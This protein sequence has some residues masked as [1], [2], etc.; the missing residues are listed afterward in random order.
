MKKIIAISVAALMTWSGFAFGG[1][2]VQVPVIAD[3]VTEGTGGAGAPA[4]A[5]SAGLDDPG[6]NKSGGKNA[7]GS[8]NA[9]QKGSGRG[10]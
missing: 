1:A 10:N 5:S 6:S 4:N 2:H 3:D 7:T 8:D 9:Q